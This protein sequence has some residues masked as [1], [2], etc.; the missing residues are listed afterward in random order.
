MLL[1]TA[2]LYLM[3][4]LNSLDGYYTYDSTTKTYTACAATAKADGTTTY[5]KPTGALALTDTNNNTITVT[6]ADGLTAF[7]SIPA[8]A[9]P[10]GVELTVKGAMF[11]ATANTTYAFEYIDPAVNYDAEEVKTHNDGLTGAISTSNVAYSFT[12]YGSTSGTPVHGNGKVKF[13][14]TEGE[15]TTVLV[16]SNTPVDANAP[17]YVGQQFKVHATTIT[18]N[19]YYELHT[20]AGVATGIYVTV[21]SSTFSADEVNAYNATLPGAISTSDVKTPAKY[22]YKVIKVQ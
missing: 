20:T 16:T 2:N 3:Q 13:V 6:P 19:T 12:S 8:T 1:P 11:T 14:S 15:W 9:S 5:Y 22:Q 18:A 10:T 4:E 17:N 21:E 7:N